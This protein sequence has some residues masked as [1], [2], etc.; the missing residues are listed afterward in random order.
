MAQTRS[1]DSDSK[2]GG[3]ELPFLSKPELETRV[4]RAAADAAFALKDPPGAR[5]FLRDDPSST[6]LVRVF[7]RPRTTI[8]RT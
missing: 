3:G 7:S 6:P 8:P 5:R 1:E 2:L 4:G